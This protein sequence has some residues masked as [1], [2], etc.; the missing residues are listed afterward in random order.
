MCSPRVSLPRL[1]PVSCCSKISHLPQFLFP[2]LYSGLSRVAP[3]Q[4][5][6]SGGPSGRDPSSMLLAGR[7]CPYRRPHDRP[8]SSLALVLA[9]ALSRPRRLLAWTT[10]ACSSRGARA[11]WG[12]L[13]ATRTPAHLP[14]SRVDTPGWCARRPRCP[15]PRGRTLATATETIAG[16][17]GT[18]PTQPSVPTMTEPRQVWHE[19]RRVSPATLSLRA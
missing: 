7:A 6:S 11:Y 9:T 16:I 8:P 17:S 12:V 15:L 2:F 3:R 5:T 10:G 19:L 13:F 14:Y 4:A 18:N 1:C